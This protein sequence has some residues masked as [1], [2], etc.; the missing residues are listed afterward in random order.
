M[1]P[2]ATDFAHR[3][4]FDHTID[5]ICKICFRTIAKSND[6]SDLARAD[7][8]HCCSVGMDSSLNEEESLRGTF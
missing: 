6:P 1:V 8:E 7:Q 4:N 5:S 2:I 3:E